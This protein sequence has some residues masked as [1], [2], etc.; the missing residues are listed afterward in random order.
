MPGCSTFHDGPKLPRVLIFGGY[1]RVQHPAQAAEAVEQL[2]GQ[3]IH[4]PPGNGVEQKKLQRT[5]LT[6]GFRTEADKLLPQAFPMTLMHLF[7]FHAAVFQRKKP[8]G[9]RSGRN[10]TADGGA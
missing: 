9:M 6:E 7:R 2:E 4:V 3:L 10:Q 8:P 5:N 1:F